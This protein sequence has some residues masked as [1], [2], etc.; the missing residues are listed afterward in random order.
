MRRG[1]DYRQNKT[2]YYLIFK[3][4]KN[5]ESLAGEKKTKYYLDYTKPPAYYNIN[6]WLQIFLMKTIAV[7]YCR[8][9]SL[10]V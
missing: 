9:F 8:T 6:S 2:V 3:N 4:Y 10:Y 1:R 5:K 7:Y